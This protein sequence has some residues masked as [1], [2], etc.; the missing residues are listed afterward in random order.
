VSIA[1]SPRH[2]RATAGQAGKVGVGVDELLAGAPPVVARV[3]YGHPPDDFV[4]EET[5]ITD[6]SPASGL[7]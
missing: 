1:S 2:R 4:D 3:H 6:Q 7:G 5:V